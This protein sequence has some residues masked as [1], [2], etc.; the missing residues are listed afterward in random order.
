[1]CASGTHSRAF[2][3]GHLLDLKTG[4]Q[5]VGDWT[6]AR[7]VP[8]SATPPTANELPLRTQKQ[9]QV[10][11]SCYFKAGFA[12]PVFLSLPMLPSPGLDMEV[13]W[14]LLTPFPILYLR[15]YLENER[16]EFKTALGWE[17]KEYMSVLDV[18]FF[19]LRFL[20]ETHA[21]KLAQER[22]F[23]FSLRLDPKSLCMTFSGLLG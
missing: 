19:P 11:V 22:G 1:M 18:L 13:N 21:E 5:Y 8:F 15:I 6:H 17:G 10:L 9:V 2:G 3:W 23:S 12:L 16:K 20:S 4:F 14:P 7:S